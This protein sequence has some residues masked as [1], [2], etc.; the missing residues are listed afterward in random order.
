MI[1]NKV[2]LWVLKS[3]AFKAS[4]AKIKRAKCFWGATSRLWA[5]IFIPKAWKTFKKALV[6]LRRV[7]TELQ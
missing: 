5:R 6:P 7:M 1:S 2:V 4:G 3:L